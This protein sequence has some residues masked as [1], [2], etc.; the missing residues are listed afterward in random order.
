MAR[1]V[2]D[3]TVIPIQ[4]STTFEGQI[5]SHIDTE[6]GRALKASNKNL[7]WAGNS[8]SNWSAGVHDHTSSD[9]TSI[10]TGVGDPDGLWLRHS[11][12]KFDNAKPNDI[13]YNSPTTDEILIKINGVI[14]AELS[15]SEAIFIP[16]YRTSV[17][18][19]DNVAADQ[20]IAVEYAMLT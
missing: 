16:R 18:L 1:I 5:F 6:I 14:I 10:G 12:Y 15:P 17:V 9:G 19:E 7:T 20:A 2:F 4:L 11:G 3:L 8:I 13:D